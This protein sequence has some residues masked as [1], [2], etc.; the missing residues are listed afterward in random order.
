MS[1][2]DTYITFSALRLHFTTDNYDYFKY[3]GKT[4]S[5]IKTFEK[6]K[7]KFFYSKLGAAFTK[8]QDLVN[9]FVANYISN[10]SPSFIGDFLDDDCDECYTK[11]QRRNQALFKYFT[12]DCRTI[13][14]YYDEVGVCYKD[15]FFEQDGKLPAIFGLFNNGNISFETLVIL[16]RLTDFVNKRNY[17]NPLSIKSKLKLKKYEHFVNIYNINRY[18]DAFV[19]IVVRGNE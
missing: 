9:F 2:F 18:G 13:K 10:K 4:R 6:C 15:I 14:A 3:N 8:K 16:N 17:I 7:G 19:S 11:W 12:D 5:N 1:P